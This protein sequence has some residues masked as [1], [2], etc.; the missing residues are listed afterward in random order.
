MGILADYSPILNREH[1]VKGMIIIV[2]DLPALEEMAMELGYVKDLNKDL[3]AILSTIYDQIL[4]V[5]NKGELL[6]FSD[7]KMQDFWDIDLHQIVGKSLIE[8]EEKEWFKPSVTR[9]VMEGKRKVSVIKDTSAGKKIMVI[10]N[11]VFDESGN[12]ER[13][14]I[15][16]RDITETTKLKSELLEMKK[17]SQQYKK[18][19][20]DLKNRDNLYRNV[21]YNSPK[22]D[23][24]MKQIEKVA[25]FSSTV[26]LTGESGV[27]KE[28]FAKAVHQLGPRA[29]RPFLKIN[30]GAIPENLLESEL[31]GYEKGAFTGADPKGRDGYFQQADQGVLFLDEIAEMPL[32]LQV[33]LLRVLQEREVIPIGSTKAIPV[34]VQIVAATNKNLEQL[35]EKGEFREDF[36]YRLNVIPICIPSLRERPEDIPPL[37]YHFLQKLNNKYNRDIQ[38]H[39]DALNL[40]EV[41]AWPGNVRE[42][43]NVIERVVVTTEEDIIYADHIHHF[44]QWKK[45]S[46]KAKPIITHLI[47][48]QEALEV[49]EEQ[50]ILLAMERY[51]TTTMAAKILGI[52][53]SSVSRKYQ[54]I[55][56]K[57]THAEI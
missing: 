55:I 56:Q 3:Q 23:A 21:V 51:K 11:P 30:C 10:G 42:L 54:K 20:E 29:N 46:T 5:N 34:D 36:F 40:L 9:L 57:Q 49:V 4:V 45:A 44:L 17:L 47:P 2:Q 35:V 1:E 32:S 7:N 8:V 24:I 48:L 12:L 16:F 25:R 33:K 43:Q 13:I 53:Q 37:A 39:P 19:L 38:L 6:R 15:A 14:V 52:S 50:L 27:G 31:F 22:I 18:E 28:V 26:L 41:Y